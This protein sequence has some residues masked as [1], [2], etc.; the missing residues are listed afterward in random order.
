MIRTTAS[1]RN[2]LARAILRSSVRTNTVRSMV[3]RCLHRK[4][5][6]RYSFTRSTAVRISIYL[7]V[8]LALSFAN[9]SL[10]LPVRSAFIS[11]IC[12]FPSWASTTSFQHSS[13]P[14]SLLASFHRLQFYVCELTS[15]ENLPLYVQNDR[16]VAVLS[17]RIFFTQV[18]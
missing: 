18:T 17:L 5:L 1:L 11:L 4:H 9:L 7:I 12:P 10:R 3:I 8:D 14:L 13:L 16:A 6:Q 15:Y 2:E